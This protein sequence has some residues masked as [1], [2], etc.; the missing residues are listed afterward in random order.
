M[1]ALLLERTLAGGLGDGGFAI[2]ALVLG[3]NNCLALRA[4]RVSVKHGKA[5]GQ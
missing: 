1:E 5:G 4:P 2:I 3:A